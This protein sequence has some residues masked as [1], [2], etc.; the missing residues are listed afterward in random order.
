MS[1]HGDNRTINLTKGDAMEI[2]DE[3]EQYLERLAGVLVMRIDGRGRW[4]TV[5]G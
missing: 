4:T 3:L 1:N 5:E 2:D